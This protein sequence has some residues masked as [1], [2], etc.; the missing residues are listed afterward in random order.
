LIVLSKSFEVRYDDKFKLKHLFGT[1]QRLVTNCCYSTKGIQYF[2]KI[3][4]LVF[5]DLSETIDE[6][7]KAAKRYKEFI[8]SEED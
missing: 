1:P 6:T 5:D 2:A 3:T 7:F 8:E 4:S